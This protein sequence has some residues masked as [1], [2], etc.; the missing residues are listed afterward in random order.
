VIT[1]ASW[2]D[3]ASDD[4]AA[5]FTVEA[6][7]WR[8]ALDWDT[9]ATWPRIEA[10]RR[11][12][13]V[14]GV[15][16]RSADAPLSGWAYWAVRGD[17]VHCGTITAT[18][19]AETSALVRALAADADRV[20]ARRTVLFAFSAAPGLAEALGAH[21]FA[22]GQYEF[23][24][25]PIAADGSAYVPAGRPWDLRDFAATAELLRAAYPAT[26]C[27]RPFAPTGTPD[28]W[29]EYVHDLV[30]AD[31]CGRFRS[32]LSRIVADTRDAADA[33][34][35]VTDLG[36]GSAHL[37]QLAVRPSAARR[38]LGRALVRSV[39]EACVRA[40]FARLTLLV[41]GTNDAA[42]RLYRDLG[43]EHRA[44]FVAATRQGARRQRAAS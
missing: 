19:A 42:R 25:A 14:P 31:G 38:G 28:A 27:L 34:A 44:S 8:D 37:A 5:A 12:G 41:S 20:G 1:T 10:A 43:F 33:V 23:L 36:H 16:T 32:S 17:E 7:R 11:D 2:Q 18:T 21:G 15:V 22:V 6:R 24:S 26:D 30:L 3:A 4:L 29:G 40:R 13:R 9:T 35:L 39:R